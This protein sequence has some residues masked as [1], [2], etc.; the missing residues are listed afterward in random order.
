MGIYKHIL[1]A[2]DTITN[3]D[4]TLDITKEMAED[5]DTT[6]SLLYTVPPINA[7]GLDYQ[8]PTIVDIEN[9][10]ICIAKE[11][12]MAAAN[13]HDIYSDDEMVAVG[14]SN[15]LILEQAR[16]KNVDL[17]IVNNDNQQAASLIGKAPCDIL[18]VHT[19]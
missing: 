1:M 13:A 2:T 16:E 17:I 11:R 7:R 8:L 19:A 5:T 14:D 3:S 12:L 4:D 10:I 15:K 18:A 6:V 9:R